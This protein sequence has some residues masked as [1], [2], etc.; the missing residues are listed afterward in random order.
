MYTDNQKKILLD[1]ASQSIKLGC[2]GLKAEDINPDTPEESFLQEIRACF[3]S[4]HK[5]HDLRGCI[6]S[7]EAYRPLQDDV[8]SNAQSAA[9]KDWRFAPVTEQELNV[10]TLEVS[11]LS[12]VKPMQVSNEADLLQQLQPPVDGLIID[13]GLG[14]R[15][16]FLPQVWEQLP[17]AEQFLKHLKRK[18]GLAENEWPESMQCSRYHCEAFQQIPS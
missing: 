9:F 5:G 3:V 6:G 8:I 7:L 14:H 13:D 10:L 16:T 12:P 15:A 1:L 17:K 11:V 4:L 18:A 2:Q